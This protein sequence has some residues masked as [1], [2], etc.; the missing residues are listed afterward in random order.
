M[1]ITR[2]RQSRPS[3]G[4]SEGRRISSVHVNRVEKKYYKCNFLYH[5]L[6][7]RVNESNQ[8]WAIKISVY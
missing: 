3:L 2:Q 4:Y 8:K 6:F 1:L 5:D 7:N